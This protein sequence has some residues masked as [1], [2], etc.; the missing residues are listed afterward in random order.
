VLTS[1]AFGFYVT[2]IASYGSLF[3]SFATIFVLLTY[4]YFSAIAF[5]AGIEI[6]AHVRER[7]TGSPDPAR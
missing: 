6:D 7:A 5:L 4:F 2:N 3:G 1:V